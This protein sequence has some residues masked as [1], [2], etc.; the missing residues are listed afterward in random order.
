MA[1]PEIILIAALARSN[2]VIGKQGKLPWS[3]PADSQHF[4]TVTLSHPIIMGRHTWE[5]DL[6]RCPL[7]QRWNIVISSSPQTLSRSQQCQDLSLGLNFV[8]SLREAVQLVAD[9]GKEKVYIV[10]GASIYAQALE[11][12]DTLDLTLVDGEHDGD[13]FFPAYE[14][15]IGSQ[16]QQISEE[17]HDG[18]SFTLY[19]RIP[20]VSE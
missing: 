16:F 10:G 9:Q 13:R 4:Q 12:A 14:H 15:L 17:P 6:D 2:R 11:I 1:Q 5:S 7:P 19:R 18:F 8:S 20:F 3:I